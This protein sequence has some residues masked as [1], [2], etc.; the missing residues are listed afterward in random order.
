MRVH[1]IKQKKCLEQDTTSSVGVQ[2][3][4]VCNKQTLAKGSMRA[5]GRKRTNYSSKRKDIGTSYI[6]E[7]FVG[8]PYV[9]ICCFFTVHV[10]TTKLSSRLSTTRAS[11]DGRTMAG[12]SLGKNNMSTLKVCM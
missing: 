11:K 7:V 9:E 3:S 6:N 5:S 1:K 10:I 2:T 8:I 4:T 12:Y